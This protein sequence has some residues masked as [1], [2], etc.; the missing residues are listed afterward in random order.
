M[1]EPLT[2]KEERLLAKPSLFQNINE[3]MKEYKGGYLQPKKL[4]STSEIKEREKKVVSF[5]K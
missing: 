1:I 5:K 4:P 3:K 2:H